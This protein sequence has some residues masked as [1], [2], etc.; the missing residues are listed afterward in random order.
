MPQQLPTPL[1]HP[2]GPSLVREHPFGWFRSALLACG[3][4]EGGSLDL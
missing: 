4:L 2:A 3:D 1:L